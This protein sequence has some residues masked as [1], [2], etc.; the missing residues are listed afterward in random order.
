MS[1]YEELVEP[2]DL[3]LI[4]FADVQ[5]QE[6][7]FLSEPYLP[8]GKITLLQGDPGGGKTMFCM[9]LAACISTG[10][11]FPWENKTER[12]PSPVLI[13]TAEDGIEDTIHPR[14]AL[15]GA[16]FDNVY[17]INDRSNPLTLMD[18][19]LARVMK[20]LH[21]ALVII[22]PLQAF[23]GANV[24]MHRANQV[25]PVLSHVGDL[26]QDNNCTVLMV[27]HLNKGGGKV[28]YRGLGSIDFNGAA[29]SVLILGRNPRNAEQ[30]IV[31]HA[32]C[33]LAPLGESLAFHIE[34]QSGIDFDGFSDLEADQIV[35]S[36][37]RKGAGKAKDAV[38]FLTS[39]IDEHPYA[40]LSDIRLSAAQAGITRRTLDRAKAQLGLTDVTVGFDPKTTWWLAPDIDVD[41]FKKMQKGVEI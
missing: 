21:P 22:D 8:A 16:N 23:L 12:Q 2:E 38:T 9:L 35:E 40:E 28:L 27:M 14:L 24:D 29:R 5:P 39:L 15:M 13:Q 1:I 10:R 25:R 4:C 30:V 20:Q 41:D 31:T 7:H 19:R 18:Q 33:N 34:S 36:V 11:P 3:S 37:R 6:V 26:A 32:K 17:Y